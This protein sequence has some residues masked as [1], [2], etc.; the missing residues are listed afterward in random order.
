MEH[1]ESRIRTNRTG[2]QT[3]HRPTFGQSKGRRGQR[4][5]WAAP[6]GA[7]AHFAVFSCFPFCSLSSRSTSSRFKRAVPKRVPS[8]PKETW[9]MASCLKSS[10][11]SFASL[12]S[13]SLPRS[14][15]KEQTQLETLPLV[16]SLSARNQAFCFT[17]SFTHCFATNSPDQTQTN[18]TSS[19]HKD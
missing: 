11:W 15:R 3:T 14:A 18:S 2:S 8:K 16:R 9:I 5:L 17:S 1:S 7:R 19:T 10:E 4:A 13:H 6:A 12:S